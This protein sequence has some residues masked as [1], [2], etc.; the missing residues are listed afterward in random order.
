[1][2]KENVTVEEVESRLEASLTPLQRQIRDLKKAGKTSGEV[3]I[4]LNEDLR[5]VNK[6]YPTL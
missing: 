2:T 1:M 4:Q 6:L 5:V 3:A